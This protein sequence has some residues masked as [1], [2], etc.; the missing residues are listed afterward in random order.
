MYLP[1]WGDIGIKHIT[2]MSNT[3]LSTLKTEYTQPELDV[4]N[5]EVSDSFL[6]TVSGTGSVEGGIGEPEE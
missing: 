4:I 3:N 2:Y 1:F 6:I 5:V